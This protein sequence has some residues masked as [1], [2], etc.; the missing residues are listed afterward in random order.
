[1][2]PVEREVLEAAR[3]AV[4]MRHGRGLTTADITRDAPRLSRLVKAVVTLE[5]TR[6]PEPGEVRLP[7]PFAESDARAA[8]SGAPAIYSWKCIHCGHVWGSMPSI[9]FADPRW[10]CKCGGPTPLG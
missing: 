5:R 10:C 6:A 9:A 4:D 3:E 1:M 2:T 8:A 7:L